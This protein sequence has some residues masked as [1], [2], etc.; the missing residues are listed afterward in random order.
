MAQSKSWTDHLLLADLWCQEMSL[1]VV[2]FR[3]WHQL[4]PNTGE[5]E[6]VGM[7]PCHSPVDG[8]LHADLVLESLH[9]LNHFAR[10]VKSALTPGLQGSMSQNRESK[11]DLRKSL[12]VVEVRSDSQELL[13]F[14][15]HCC[16]VSSQLMAIYDHQLH[17]D[18]FILS[19]WE[20][21][22]C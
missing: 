17:K 3:E 21:L 10:Q 6:M 15:H 22:T 11:W 5:E 16:R 13:N 7:L 1:S 8:R 2:L 18:I 19:H 4:A 9:N 12:G 20:L 14:I